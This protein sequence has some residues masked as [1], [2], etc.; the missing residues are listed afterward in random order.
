[1]LNDAE[2]MSRFII[3]LLEDADVLETSGVSRKWDA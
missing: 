2:C 1:M 3:L